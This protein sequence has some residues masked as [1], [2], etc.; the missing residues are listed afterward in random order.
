MGFDLFIEL[1]LLIDEH[2]GL[3][4]VYIYGGKK[5]FNVMDFQVPTQYRKFLRQHGKWISKYVESFEGNYIS[6]DLFLEC[7]PEWESVVEG[8]DEDGWTKEDHEEFK[9]ALEWFSSKENYIVSWSY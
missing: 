8:Y 1:N 9:K 6:T 5:D 2:T 3:P 4:I 7:Y